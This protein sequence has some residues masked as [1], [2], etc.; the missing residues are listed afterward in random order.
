MPRIGLILVRA[1]VN[2][3]RRISEFLAR[4]L[5]RSDTGFALV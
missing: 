3:Y 5:R 2:G 4:T 1:Y